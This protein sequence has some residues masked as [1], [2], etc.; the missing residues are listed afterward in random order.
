MIR[1]KKANRISARGEGLAFTRYLDDFPVIPV[2]NVWS[3]TQGG[4]FIREAKLYA[5][6]T[7]T[8][9]IER[10][11][12]MTT[13]PGDL[14]LDPTGGSGTT[15]YVS[16][17]WG[18]RWISI[19]A[20]RVAIAIARQRLLTAKFD[21]F[22]L[23]PTSA[24]D[25]E[26]N[27][28]GPWLH[29]P[30]G[31]IKG[32]C[33]FDCK[34]VPH[35]TLK[36]I[37]QNQALDPIFD[38]W[39]PVLSEKLAS[40]NNAL[41]GTVTKEIREA[42]LLKLQD[43]TRKEGKRAI[44][45]ADE[46]RWRLPDKEW[47]EWEVPFDTDADWPDSLKT[48][49]TE[50]RQA[51]R[52]KM[53]EVNACIAARADQ[54]ELVDQPYKDNKKVRVAGP[55][56]VEGVIPA[57]ESIDLES[58]E[59]PIG[60]APDSLETFDGEG[61]SVASEAQNSEAYVDRMVRLLREDGVR[62]PDNRVMKFA[63]LEVLAEGSVLHAKGAWGDGEEERQVAV[64]FGPQYGSLNTLMVEDGIRAASRRGFDDIVFAAFSFDATAQ[65]T[66]QDVKDPHVRLHMA[67]VRPDVAMGD[68]LKTTV[69]SQLFTVSG[70]PRTRL[71][72]DRDGS[73]VVEMEGVDI[74][75]P[76]SNSVRSTGASKVAAW[77]LDTDYDGRCFC[78]TQAFFPDKSAWDKLAK[79]LKGTLDEEAFAKL[80]GTISVPFPAG[81]YKRVAVKV[82]D[83]RG[84]EVMRVHSLEEYHV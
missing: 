41:S 38:K 49:L 11:L 19:D 20:S 36:S 48:A 16:E 59:S 66:I 50:Y 51:W 25:V 77:F 57:E 84:N 5:V 21:Y 52:Q 35:I 73:F 17:Q 32:T 81:T 2:T 65:W 63:E 9:V 33:T 1:L 34:T 4:G 75:D 60:G 71:A 30:E 28:D 10:C 64:M 23:R 76:V 3:D 8:T 58:E 67:Q 54:E 22:R 13:D 46:R 7:A 47:K 45:D 6:Q 37:A 29:D 79:A 24:S 80:S 44:T 53:D 56:T 43:K 55:F 70:T 39:E 27:P 72:Q 26:R 40:L 31:T 74:Y 82:I 14:V 78:V 69:S 12:L 62:F 42:L 61:E 18:R 83:T 15:A 68:L